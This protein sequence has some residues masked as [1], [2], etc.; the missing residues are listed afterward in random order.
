M[1]IMFTFSL[2]IVIIM[3]RNPGG[4]YPDTGDYS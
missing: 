3:A 4:T 1:Q 2:S